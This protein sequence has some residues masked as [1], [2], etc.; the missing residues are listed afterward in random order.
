MTTVQEPRFKVG[1]KVYITAMNIHGTIISFVEARIP[2]IHD[3]VYTIEYPDPRDA[4]VLTSLGCH[5]DSMVK[6]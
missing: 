1:D 2:A 4:G 6:E 5:E 3:I